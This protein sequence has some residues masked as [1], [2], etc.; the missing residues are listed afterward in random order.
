MTGGITRRPPHAQAVAGRSAVAP[1]PRSHAAPT[2]AAASGATDVT[3]PVTGATTT[4]T[5]R[6]TTG[7]TATATA[8]TMPPPCRCHLPCEGDRVSKRLPL[9]A[10]RRHVGG[11]GIDRGERTGKFWVVRR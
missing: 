8:T 3:L 1:F 4:G 11:G 9:R 7:T 5:T 6:T 2:S 10:Q